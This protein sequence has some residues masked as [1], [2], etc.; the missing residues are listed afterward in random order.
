MADPSKSATNGWGGSCYPLV[1]VLVH[2]VGDD[3]ACCFVQVGIFVLCAGHGFHLGDEEQ[4]LLVGTE[5]ETF[6]VAFVVGELTAFRS[7]RVHFPHLAAAAFTAQV[8][9]LGAS[10]DP[11]GLAFVPRRTGQLRIGAA[12]GVHHE[13]FGIAL[14]LGH[15]VVAHGVSHLFG[16]GRR[17]YTSDASHGPEGFGRHAAVLDADIRTSDEVCIAFFRGFGRAA[18]R[19]QCHHC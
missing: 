5:R 3:D 14:V 19:S 17:G 18:A 10:L 7:V 16:V 1:P 13:K 6:D 11:G 2:Q 4:T 12:V 8:S 15:T 9:Q